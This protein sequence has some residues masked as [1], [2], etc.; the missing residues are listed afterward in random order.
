M[1]M[2]ATAIGSLKRDLAL[3]NELEEKVEKLSTVLNKYRQDYIDMVDA[4]RLL[5]TI[6]DEN[7][8]ATLRFITGVVNKALAEIFP[9]D[10]RKITLKKRLFAGTKP[11]I[12][13]ELTNGKGEVLDLSLQ[14]G[15]GLNQVVSG[16]FLI[17]LVEVRKGRRLVI[18]DEKFSG[19]HKEAKAILSEII[20]IFAEGGFQFIF[21][22]YGMNNIGK[23]YNV[24]KP[25]D[26]SNAFPLD[27]DLEYSDSDVFLFTGRP[28]NVDLDES[29]NEAQEEEGFLG[30]EEI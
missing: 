18:F 26:V 24:E 4:Q 13:V 23:I 11:H 6:S 10:T 30:E 5:A 7:T 9:S 28:E 27:G 16:L 25:S 8:E 19:L 14:S 21:V 17:C 2:Y 20:K 22:E 3:R 1:S 15:T 29:Y 12:V